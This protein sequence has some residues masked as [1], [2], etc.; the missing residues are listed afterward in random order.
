[1]N[2]TPINIYLDMDGTLA[3]F[4]NAEIFEDFFTPGFF[5]NL[6]PQ[7]NI[8]SATKKLYENEKEFGIRVYTLSS[9]IKGHKTA[10]TEKNNWLDKYFPELP[11]S[12][13]KYTMVGENK[14]DK[15]KDPSHSILLDDFGPL[16]DD[17]IEAGGIAIKVSRNACD[18]VK[19]QAKFKHAHHI[20]PDMTSYQIVKYVMAIKEY[21]FDQDNM[22]DEKETSTKKP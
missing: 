13:R 17:F 16:C 22:N 8:L 2:K 18:T 10:R 6:K 15:I 3:V 7:R 1:M 4:K 21:Y 12:R 5:Y 11:K 9:I 19:E 14:A 20:D